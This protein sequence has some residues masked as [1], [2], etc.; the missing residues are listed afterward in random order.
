M[1]KKLKA[2]VH[3]VRFK[4]TN[5]PVLSPVRGTIICKLNIFYSLDF[6]EF[7]FMWMGAL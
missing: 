3:V 2:L 6:T 5:V 4:K 7:S 1:P